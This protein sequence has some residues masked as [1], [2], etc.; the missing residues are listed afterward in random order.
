[1]RRLSRV[2]LAAAAAA[3][4]VGGDP[5]RGPVGGTVIIAAAADADALLPPL[6]R[7]SQGRLVSELLF[8]RLAEIGPALNTFGDDGFEPRLARRWRWSAD[9][10]AIS[11]EINPAARWHDGQPVLGRDLLS[12]LAAIR[13]PANGSSLRN[14]LSDLDSIALDGDRTVTLHFAR[15]SLEQFYTAARIF[16]LPTHLLPP[17]GAPLA[18]SDLARQGIGSG[19]YRLVSWE[20]LSRLELVAVDDHYR[21]RARLDRVV[22]SVAPEP[23]T[24]LAKLWAGEAD[25][26]ELLPAA[27][28]A[29]AARHAHVRVVPSG[30]FEYAFAAFNFRDRSDRD[31]PHPLFRDH[32]M[33]RAIA[34]A[35]DRPGLVRAIFDTLA[36]PLHGPFVRAQ[37]TSDTTV[38]QLP[39]DR[40]AAA[41]LLDSL[42]WRLGAR[43]GI[44]RRDGRRLTFTALVPGSSRNR[45]R[46]AVLMQEQLRQVGVAMEIERAE[47]RVFTTK[48]MAGHFDVVFG[49]WLTTPSPRGLRGTWMSRTP[50]GRGGQNDGSYASAAF[51]AAVEAGVAAMDPVAARRRFRDAYQIIVDDAAALFLYEPRAMA[52][53]HTRL[54]MPAWRSDGWWRALPEWSVDPTARL[55]RDARPTA[56]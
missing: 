7:T 12:G 43:D 45:E 46:A 16:P 54:R 41:L 8:D 19:P 49:G 15:R 37:H 13:D 1:M 27:D 53:V 42:G 39:F 21:G 10:L 25:V 28:L 50:D 4:C 52:A 47:N 5:A 36:L 34:M 31:R 40:A 22:L 11:F 51:D 17:A 26:W 56:P 35:V 24:G 6:V 23:A 9:S 30:A 48:R 2:L 55:P 38:R 20:P 18:T 33:R 29:E 32:A 14:E 3:A 44:R